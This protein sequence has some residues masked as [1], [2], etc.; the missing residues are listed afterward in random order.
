MI[1]SIMTLE[2]LGVISMTQREIDETAEEL[3][4]RI[5]PQFDA[6]DIDNLSIEV[7]EVIYETEISGT[8][9]SDDFK[10][11]VTLLEDEVIND[12]ETRVLI[13]YLND[14]RHAA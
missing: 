3:F 6:V 12:D 1:S 7:R 13:M 2:Q 5:K 9:A 4:Q 11:L 8:T 14:K 10:R